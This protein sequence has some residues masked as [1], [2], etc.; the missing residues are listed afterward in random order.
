MRPRSLALRTARPDK[1]PASYGA[2]HSQPSASHCS[3][4]A[5]GWARGAGAG[6][7]IAVG[8]DV[9]VVRDE[10]SHE[11][12]FLREHAQA[13]VVRR[14]PVLVRVGGLRRAVRGHRRGSRQGRTRAGRVGAGTATRRTELL[15][16]CARQQ[17][18][19]GRAL[20]LGE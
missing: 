10:Q 4:V 7:A 15:R 13:D 2:R 16:L 5:G 18:A 20:P 17:C 14:H 19:W 6:A 9:G 12:Y 11:R 8:E 3:S 1:P